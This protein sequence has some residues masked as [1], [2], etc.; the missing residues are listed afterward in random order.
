[1]IILSV[2][3]SPLS[4]CDEQQAKEYLANYKWLT[5]DYPPFNY[6][7]EQGEL[8]GIATDTLLRVY[9][10][11]EIKLTSRDILIVPWARL[12]YNMETYDDYAAY[13][14]IYTDDRAKAFQLVTTPLKVQVSIMVL[15]ERK[16]ELEDKALRELKIAVV[17]E[18]IGH[19]LIESQNITAKQVITT[20]ASSMLQMLLHHRVDAIA[21]AEDVAIFQ[22]NK[23]ALDQRNIVPVHRLNAGSLNSFVFH[24]TTPKCVTS[25][26]AKTMQ[27]L[28]NKNELKTIRDKY[29][30]LS[31]NQ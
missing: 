9:Q 24:K 18:D 26:F 27:K 4:A 31:R 22:F 14:M 12:Y 19:Q 20:S 13:S 3:S 1:M 28:H 5:E 10:E 16:K 6:L 8:I 30:A 15:E 7:D 25:L 2:F 29:L 21:Y 23:L 11:L 17:R